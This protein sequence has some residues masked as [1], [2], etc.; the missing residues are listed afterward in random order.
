MGVKSFTDLAAWQRADELRRTILAIT[1]R[2]IV[3]KDFA[4]CDQ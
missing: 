1:A 4:F 3:A 2:P